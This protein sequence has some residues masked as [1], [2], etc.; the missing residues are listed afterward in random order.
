MVRFWSWSRSPSCLSSTS[1]VSVSTFTISTL[2]FRFFVFDAL[3]FFEFPS[4]FVAFV[5]F[6]ACSVVV[7]A[8]VVSQF[9]YNSKPNSSKLSI[10]IIGLVQASTSHQSTSIVI[11]FN[12]VSR[13]FF[14]I[15]LHIQFDVFPIFWFYFV[16]FGDQFPFSVSS[17]GYS[18]HFLDPSAVFWTFLRICPMKT[19]VMLFRKSFLG[20][21]RPNQ[22]NLLL[23]QLLFSTTSCLLCSDLWFFSGIPSGNDL[24]F[25]AV[26]FLDFARHVARCSGEFFSP[27]RIHSFFSPFFLAISLFYSSNWILFY[28]D[29]LIWLEN[30]SCFLR[31]LYHFFQLCEA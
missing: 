15:H 7:L 16:Q 20:H 28:C 29:V 10:P 19:L 26:A 12:F 4:T 18:R 24:T 3:Q 27:Q 31:V 8:S 6:S 1:F 9:C 5:S 2:S 22:L 14:P 25:A 11:P 13:L 23:P 21:F 30:L 17:E